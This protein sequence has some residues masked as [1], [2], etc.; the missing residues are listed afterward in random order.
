MR[1][2]EIGV[3]KVLG[4]S[5]TTIIRLLV[6]DFLQWVLIANLFAWPLAWYGASQW[7]SGFAYRIEIEPVVFITASIIGIII[8]FITVFSQAWRAAISNP[9]DAIKYE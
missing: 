1:I 4:A 8:A 5:N 9:L 6:F 7:L 2:K 3:R